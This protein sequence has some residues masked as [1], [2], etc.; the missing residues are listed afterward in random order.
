MSSVSPIKPEHIHPA[1]WRASQL[2]RGNG[3]YLDTG[4][5]EL[6]AELPGGGWPL[7]QLTEILLAQTGTAELRLLKPALC[8]LDNRPVILLAP[9]FIPQALA[10]ADAGLQTTQ[11]IWIRCNKY[12]DAL[13]AAEQVLR[14]GSCGALLFWQSQIR[15]EALRR[16]HLAA[17]SSDT[18]FFLMRTLRAAQAPSPAPLRLSLRPSQNGLELEIIKRRGSQRDRP[19]SI[20]LPL[21]HYLS[22]YAGRAKENI[23]AISNH[24]PTH[25]SSILDR[26]PLAAA[27][28]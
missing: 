26:H 3:G 28:T 8:Q 12:V 4:Y 7:G 19:I 1:L 22:S 25:P 13:W 6:K 24:A 14:N 21:H 16:L 2:A 5:S 15:S 10:L 9:P 23:P 27:S 20:Y 18:L 11:L 17:Q